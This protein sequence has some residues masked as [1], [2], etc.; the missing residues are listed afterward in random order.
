[1]DTL[2]TQTETDTRRKLQNRLRR[3]EGQVR[4][5]STMIS[6]GRP[7]EDVVIQVTAIRG[8]LDEALRIILTEHVSECLATLPPDDARQGITRAISLLARL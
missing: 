8:A 4:A 7:C 2:A 1:M 3:L 6:E 5:V